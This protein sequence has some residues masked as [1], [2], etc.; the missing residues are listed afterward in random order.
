M[1]FIDWLIY[2][3]LDFSISVTLPIRLRSISV[4]YIPASAVVLI[5]HGQY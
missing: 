5:D 1:L 4:I 3:S 2:P